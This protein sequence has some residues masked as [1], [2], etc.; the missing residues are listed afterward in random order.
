[1]DS[2]QR[3]TTY[4]VTAASRIGNCTNSTSAATAF[5][6]SITE[7]TNMRKRIT[8]YGEIAGNIWMPVVECTKSL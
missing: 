8:L 4:A 3:C 7:E 5:T 2:V 6:A 1:M